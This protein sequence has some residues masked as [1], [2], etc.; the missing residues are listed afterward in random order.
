MGYAPWKPVPTSLAGR[1]GGN[2]IPLRQD[3]AVSA[4]PQWDLHTTN[5]NDWYQGSPDWSPNYPAD[6]LGMR[7]GFIK[8]AD[9]AWFSSHHHTAGRP[10]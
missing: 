5:P 9:V 4:K 10:E 6:F 2:P 8:R 3:W 7:P 1:A